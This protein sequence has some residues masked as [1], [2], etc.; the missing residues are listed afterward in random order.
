MEGQW[1][2]PSS[3]NDTYSHCAANGKIDTKS[4]SILSPTYVHTRRWIWAIIY[5][6][7]RW[8]TFSPIV[9]IWISTIRW[10]VKNCWHFRLRFPQHC[11]PVKIP[12]N[13]FTRHSREMSRSQ[14]AVTKSLARPMFGRRPTISRAVIICTRMQRT[15]RHWCAV[16]RKTG[17]S[18]HLSLAG[19]GFGKSPVIW[20]DA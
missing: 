3:P 13:H 4:I 15:S 16:E 17:A 1:H 6:R 11:Q 7:T 8:I 18:C 10:R 14:A 12:S 19:S 9:R 2:H 20:D 5:V